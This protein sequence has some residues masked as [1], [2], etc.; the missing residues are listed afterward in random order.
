MTTQFVVIAPG[1]ATTIQDFGRIGHQRFGIPVSGAL[2]RAA[3]SAANITVGNAP[4]E[5]GF[6]CL[7]GG[8]VLEAIGGSARVAVAGAGAALRIASP[9]GERHVQACESAL[10]ERGA[11]VTVVIAGPSISAYMAVA[12]G[13]D[14]PPFLGS[15][16]T[17]KR[18]GLGG[19]DGRALQAGDSI[20]LRQDQERP[21]EARLLGPKLEPASTVRVVLGPQ[22]DHFTAAAIATL[23]SER[24]T[25]S[26]ASD[27]MGLR[28]SG[29]RLAHAKDFNIVSD[30]I[31]PGAIQVPGDGQPIVLLAD[32][33]TTGGYPK[34]ATVISA[35]LPALGRVGPGATLRFEQ[36]GVSQAERLA[37]E[38]A[39]EIAG[40]P[41]RLE[42]LSEMSDPAVLLAENLIS[43]VTDAEGRT[44]V[45][46]SG[47]D[48]DQ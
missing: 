7:Y 29:P 23:F 44:G 34:I 41:N 8:P 21:G 30:A 9:A 2:D 37:R 43:G 4:G 31:P 16:S 24:F 48:T 22:E 18:A 27:R 28:L 13:I 3:L 15:R 42:R 40:W 17:Y 10:I 39:Q 33:Q 26:A 25:V 45:R 38:L 5:A 20:P 47:S 36:I 46:P 32:R 14:V 1:L 19:L 35:D 12:G 11:R 6:E